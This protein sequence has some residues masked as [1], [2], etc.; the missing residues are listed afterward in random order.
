MNASLA[1]R[2]TLTEV[3]HYARALSTNFGSVSTTSTALDLT[4]LIT[5]GTG[6][7]ERIGRSIFVKGVFVEG[8][9][10]GGQSNLVTDDNHNTVRI[11]MVRGT[12]ATTA[13]MVSTLSL[14]YGPINGENISGVKQVLMDR[15]VELPSPGPD[16]TGYMPALKHV[17]FYVPVNKF[18]T[19]FSSGPSDESIVLAAV[20]DSTAVSHPGFT[21][22][23]LDILFTDS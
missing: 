17:R 23:W 11:V 13:A 21:S 22:G 12:P 18:I 20:S 16:S 6:N 3:K 2:Q 7:L 1:P 10:H 19:Y 9:L 5:A 8:S 14:S 4:N 15:S